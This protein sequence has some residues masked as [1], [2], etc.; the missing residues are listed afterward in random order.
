MN[1]QN[2]EKGRK[3]IKISIM[4]QMIEKQLLTNDKWC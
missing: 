1:I 2:S 4:R 3:L